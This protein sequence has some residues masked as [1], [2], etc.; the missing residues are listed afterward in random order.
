M[1]N[2]NCEYCT[3]S[4]KEGTTHEEI[5]ET[6]SSTPHSPTAVDLVSISEE[7]NSKELQLVSWKKKDTSSSLDSKNPAIDSSLTGSPTCE[8]SVLTRVSCEHLPGTS[9]EGSA[10]SS[11]KC[12]NVFKTTRWADQVFN[13]IHRDSHD[14]PNSLRSKHSEKVVQ[15][16]MALPLSSSNETIS[17]DG[18]SGTVLQSEEV[19]SS[20]NDL[21]P[22]TRNTTTTMMDLDT[23]SSDDEGKLIIEL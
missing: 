19:N 8:Q 5:L 9:L 7:I 1:L 11:S 21:Q 2:C 22:S 6:K 14:A 15:G 16:S 23:S 13:K 20:R 12:A 10:I 3:S 4:S 18:P 17:A